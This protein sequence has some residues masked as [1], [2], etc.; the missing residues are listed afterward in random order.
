MVDVTNKAFD[1][2]AV[3]AEKVTQL[4]GEIAAA[5]SEQAQGVEQINKAVSEMD[6]VV[7]NNAA[8]AEESASASEEMNAQAAQMKSVAQ[9]LNSLIAGGDAQPRARSVQ[10]DPPAKATALKN[11]AAGK[12][13]PCRQPNP[14]EVIPMGDSECF[15]GF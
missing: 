3:Q 7:Q 1:E 12:S 6:K 10:A 14:A 4:I 5:S 11:A 2:V 8:T 9:D 13:A 15:Q